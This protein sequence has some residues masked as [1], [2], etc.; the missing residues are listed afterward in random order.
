M[1]QKLTIFLIKS[2]FLSLFISS[3]S[4]CKKISQNEIEKELNPTSLSVISNIELRNI[5]NTL[6]KNL[7]LS[8]KIKK[9][10]GVLRWDIGIKVNTNIFLVPI[11][12][13]QEHPKAIIQFERKSATF[14]YN[15][16]TLRKSNISTEADPNQE[17]FNFFSKSLKKNLQEK[18]LPP[19]ELTHYINH[20][21]IVSKNISSNLN[22]REGGTQVCYTYQWCNYGD[23]PECANGCD[24]CPLCVEE[25]CYISDPGPGGG[26]GSC[27]PNGSQCESIEPASGGGG[28]GS[29]GPL[30]PLQGLCPNTFNLI[31]G[32]DHSYWETNVLNLRFENGPNSVNQFNAYYFLGNDITDFKMN[33]II[34]PSPFGVGVPPKTALEYCQDFFPLLF[35]TG[36]ITSIWDPTI[37]THVWRFS[38]Y[39]A[40]LISARCSNIAS[41]NVSTMYYGV[42]ATPNF[43]PAQQEFRSQTSALLKCFFPSTGTVCRLFESASSNSSIAIYSVT[44]H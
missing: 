24:H 1:K 41:I 14:L 7:Q 35:T 20:K 33:Q 5:A 30:A 23:T 13:E 37:S 42:A 26:G 25:V 8:E 17:L 21:N 43:T 19:N 9:N 28:G 40:Q 38:K 36:D 10:Y 3:I 27:G 34:Y 2:V 31:E 6:T 11:I 12:S 29:N 15:I 4:S 18:V 44:C 22:N 32:N 16:I 39:A